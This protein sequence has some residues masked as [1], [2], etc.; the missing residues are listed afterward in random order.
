MTPFD[1]V[2]AL[3]LPS[4]AFVDRRIPRTLLVENG[5]FATGDRRCIREGVKELKWIAALKPT[6][7]GVAAYADAEREYVE[8]AVLKLEL[9]SA[10]R[11]ERL[12][13]LVHRAVP[14]PV[15]LIACM[16]GTPELSLAHKRRSL[17][18]A[19]KTVIDGAIVTARLPDECCN[20]SLGPFRKAL[21][22]ERQPRGT[23][24]DLYQ[25][26]VDAVRAFQ[27][28]AITGGF[29]LSPTAAAASGRAAALRDYWRLGKRIETLLSVADKETQMSRRA[30]MN[31]ELARL[32]AD[33]AAARDR[34]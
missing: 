18:E 24:K 23:L 20:G 21:A 32:R 22:L 31:M 5:A 2:A 19:G 13:D 27:A 33:R 26:W 29:R 4:D 1:P 8:I 9:R 14:Y 16:D 11:G 34:L 17:S 12:V 7:V 3:A 10:A 28:A 15:L 6:T 25:G 30:E